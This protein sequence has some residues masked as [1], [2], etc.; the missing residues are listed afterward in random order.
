ML[1][2]RG[3]GSWTS[4]T[5]VHESPLSSSTLAATQLGSSRDLGSPPEAVAEACCWRHHWPPREPLAPYWRQAELPE[6]QPDEAHDQQPDQPPLL[7]E[8]SACAPVP[9]PACGGTRGARAREKGPFVCVSSPRYNH[10]GWPF[11]HAL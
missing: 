3:Y 5:P 7:P 2:L 1:L 10:P 4:S 9:L 8:E 11:A 6:P